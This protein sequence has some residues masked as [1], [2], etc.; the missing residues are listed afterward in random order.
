MKKR[1][2]MRGKWQKKSAKKRKFLKKKEKTSEKK[3]R[4]NALKMQGKK[5]EDEQK[6]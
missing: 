5:R 6:A 3:D 2:K 4:E 1:R